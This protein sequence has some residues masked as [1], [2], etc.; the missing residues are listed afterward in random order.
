M[1]EYSTFL[2]PSTYIC[3]H[4]EG[5]EKRNFQRGE[6]KAINKLKSKKLKYDPN[7]KM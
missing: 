5:K 4:T 6:G 3:P 1:A 7:V 2:C